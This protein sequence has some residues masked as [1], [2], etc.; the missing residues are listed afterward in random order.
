M[1]ID[2]TYVIHPLY[3]PHDGVFYKNEF[4]VN[5]THNLE[6]H[7]YDQYFSLTQRIPYTTGAFFRG[8]HPVDQRTFLVGASRI[9][10]ARTAA[11]VYRLV[12]Q[13]RAGQHFDRTSSIKLV[14]RAAGTIIKSI[15]FDTFQSVHPEVH[16]IIP[17][18]RP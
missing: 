2:G 4:Y 18:T 7:I 16:K 14:D 3:G 17:L 5:S 12:L 1:T 6:T 10:P 8:L 15:P 9:D 13:G 11:T